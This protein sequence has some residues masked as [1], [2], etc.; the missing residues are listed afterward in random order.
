[1]T[2]PVSVVVVSRDRPEA[3]RRCILAL[4]QV[5][6]SPFEIVVVSD[7]VGLAAVKKYEKHI[8]FVSFGDANISIARNLGVSHAAGEVIAFIDDDS[9]PEP[10][11][12]RYLVEPFSDPEVQQLAVL[13]LGAT[14]SA[15]SG[16]RVRLAT[17]GLRRTWWSKKHIQPLLSRPLAEQ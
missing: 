17:T 8:K 6:Y 11:W 3:L 9:V 15:F 14:V 10:T 1:M 4:S 13:C 16:K 2:I 7:A 12:L 5:Q